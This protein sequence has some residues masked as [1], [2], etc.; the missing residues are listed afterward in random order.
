MDSISI[1]EDAREY[2]TKVLQRHGA[3]EFSEGGQYSLSRQPFADGYVFYQKPT[4]GYIAINC[5]C[6]C[7]IKGINQ[8]WEAEMQSLAE[9]AE[10]DIKQEVSDDERD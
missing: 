4:N 5:N 6:S 2:F 1:P 9:E 7:G 10:K 3:A 8:I